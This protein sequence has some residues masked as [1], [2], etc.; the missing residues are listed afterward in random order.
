MAGA[1][2]EFVF[3][4]ADDEKR[5]VCEFLTAAWERFERASYWETGWFWAYRQVAAYESGPDGGLVRLVFEGTPDALL[6]AERSHWKDFDGLSTWSLRRYD[7]AGYDSLLA[8]QRDAKG[9]VGG[10]REYR[11]KPLAAR[12]SL[13]YLDEFDD[14][15][16]PVAPRSA[17]NV[18]GIGFW[19]FVH[20][21]LVQSGYD[22]YDEIAIAERLLQNRLKSIA[23]YRGE[24]AA[25]EEYRRIRDRLEDVESSLET[26]MEF[27]PTGQASEP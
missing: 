22:W 3:E 8:Q 21:L 9:P 19:A 1:T 17:E 20:D 18:V 15:L 12:V 27:N 11:L 24:T 23:S 13:L 4:T 2:I 16:A 7:E 25:R 10:E 5:F 26:W 6:D 14:P